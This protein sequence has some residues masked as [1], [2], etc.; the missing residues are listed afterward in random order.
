MKKLISATTTALLVLLI[1]ALFVAYLY[2]STIIEGTQPQAGQN[3][4][5]QVSHQET[6]FAP[7]VSFL[8]KG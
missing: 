8:L 7:G 5:E 2:N 6:S 3:K 4:I 1:P